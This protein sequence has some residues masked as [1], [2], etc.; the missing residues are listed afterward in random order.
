VV[1]MRIIEVVASLV[2]EHPR[3]LLHGLGLVAVGATCVYLATPAR[4]PT[5]RHRNRYG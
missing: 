5:R 3:E 4:R 2:A 1:A